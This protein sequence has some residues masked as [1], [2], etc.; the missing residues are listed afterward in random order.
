MSFFVACIALMVLA[1]AATLLPGRAGQM[2][3]RLAPL[4]I[5]LGAT[6]GLVP[7]GWVLA[8]GAALSARHDWALPGASLALEIDALSA[9]F[10]LP[11]LLLLALAA[12]YGRAYLAGEAGTRRLRVHW[13]AYGAL[14]ASMAL[15]LVA[16]NALLF[17]VAWEGM[18]LASFFLVT[19]D[20][21]DEQVCAAGWTYLVAAHVG[22]A[23]LL[24]FF[25]L[26][27][28]RAGSLDFAAFAGAAAGG[29]GTGGGC[30]FLLALIGFGTKAGFLPLHVWLPEAHPAAPSHVSALM[31]GVMLKLGIYGL[32]RSLTLLGPPAA[33][34]G[35]VLVGVGLSTA[36]GGVL[37]ALAQADLK[38]LLA[39]SSIEHVGIIALGLGAGLFGVQA[40][41]PAMAALGFAGALLHVLNHAAGKSLLFLAAG[42]VAHATGTRRLEEL[43]GLL[44]RMPVTGRCFVAAS[45]A[46][47]GLPPLNGFAGE[48]LIYL[49]AFQAI[50]CGAT[51]GLVVPGVALVAGLA[52]TGGL[53]AACFTR[54][55]GLVFLGE[56]RSA[57]AANAHEAPAGMR[58]PLLGLAAV[59]AGLALAA[60]ALLRLM[61][62]LLAVLCG[63]PAVAEAAPWAEVALWGFVL[64]SLLFVLLSLWLAGGSAALVRRHGE[65]AAGT[66]DCGYARPTTRMQ[67]SAT[68][69]A[70]PLVDLFHAVLRTRKRFEPPAGL[71]PSTAR[72]ASQA[73]D[74]I[75]EA[76]LRPAFGLFA[77][78][79]ADLRWLQ[80][81]R[82][83]L[84]VLYIALTLIALLIWNL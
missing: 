9:F 67:Y 47:A 68:S 77:E 28:T 35:W 55:A 64:V 18:T 49:A 54:A 44:R 74:T 62:P 8:G 70:Q 83:H 23:C 13:C 12:G 51:A 52:L 81:G 27:G 76:W 25:L 46:L 71:F 41:L 50:A 80:H 20:D 7:A 24:A 36:L 45:A 1:G 17:L 2:A 40:G 26:L 4:L 16:R 42:A 43:G 11:L 14:A 56:P 31:S 15:V 32:L 65:A 21:T 82:L 53:A 33:W 48:F 79:L 22:T 59:C 84:Y 34:W 19:R 38:R 66:W 57:A 39:Y 73:P 61:R 78:R 37:F 69:F 60:P 10:L 75:R 29:G 63:Q 3:E 6:L 58:W 30:L 5:G 72:F